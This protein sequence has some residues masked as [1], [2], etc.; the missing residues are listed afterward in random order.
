MGYASDLGTGVVHDVCPITGYPRDEYGHLLRT[1]SLFDGSVIPDWNK[2]GTELPN[3]TSPY[4]HL[5]FAI[6]SGDDFYCFDYATIDAGPRGLFI[7]FHSVIN[8]ESGGFIQDAPNGYVVLPCNTMA[9]KAFA[10]RESFGLMDQALE[11]CYYGDIKHSVRGWNQNPAYFPICVA[12]SFYEYKFKDRTGKQYSTRKNNNKAHKIAL[13]IA[14]GD[15][16]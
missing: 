3:F 14:Y 7:V 5:D 13:S 1:T 12:Q 16:A 10:I 9:E 11:W 8:Y 4:G 2:R 6:G 15:K